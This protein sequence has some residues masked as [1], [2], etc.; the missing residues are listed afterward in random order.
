MESDDDE[1]YYSHLP[2]SPSPAPRLR[3]KGPRNPLRE[4][5]SIPRIPSIPSVPP[6]PS[7]P[8]TRRAVHARDISIASSI[9]SYKGVKTE[10]GQAALSIR[11][12]TDK[13]LIVADTG[14]SAKSPYPTKPS[15]ILSPR[16]N[17]TTQ[18]DS[19]LAEFPNVIKEEPA[20]LKVV[21]VKRSPSLVV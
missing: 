7:R 17:T 9:G 14:N 20:A 4:Q 18:R 8:T 15:Q 19:L 21:T 5:P 13:S 2:P 1:D 12:V 16:R 6:P 10:T 11:P 3:P